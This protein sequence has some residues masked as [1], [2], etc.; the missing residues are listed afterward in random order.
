MCIK[1]VAVIYQNLLIK[2]KK[3]RFLKIQNFINNL[4]FGQIFFNIL[5][6]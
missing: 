5:S 4:K 3:V 6:L 1:T 2:L